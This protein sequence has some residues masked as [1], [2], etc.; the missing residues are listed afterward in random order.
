[1]TAPDRGLYSPRNAADYLDISTET[2]RR[3]VRTGELLAVKLGGSTRYARADLD[4]LIERLR[5]KEA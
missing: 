4:A 3:L 1:M 5:R 2:L